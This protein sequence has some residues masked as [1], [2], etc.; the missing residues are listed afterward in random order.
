MA[1][2]CGGWLCGFIDGFSVVVCVVVC[3]V[4]RCGLYRGFCGC[5]WLGVVCVVGWLG[6][7]VGGMVRCVDVSVLFVSF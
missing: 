3:V 5:V 4:L 6:C 7:V 2:G 1:V